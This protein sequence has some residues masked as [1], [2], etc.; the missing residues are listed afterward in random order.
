MCRFPRATTRASRASVNE[1]E[2][3]RPPTSRMPPRADLTSGLAC[4]HY[5]TRQS[6]AES[7]LT[8]TPFA[9]N[10][11][12]H[13]CHTMPPRSAS[14]STILPMLSSPATGTERKYAVTWIYGRE[15][16]ETRIHM[17]CHPCWHGHDTCRSHALRRGT[18]LYR[19]GPRRRCRRWCHWRQGNWP[20][21]A[22]SRHRAG[23]AARPRP[24][25]SDNARRPHQ[26][27]LAP[28]PPLESALADPT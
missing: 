28:T 15:H 2:H 11:K 22:A 17:W 24:R 23:A 10:H 13:R 16:T 5:T 7:C 8:F 21:P 1:T 26:P 27:R 6:H 18:P 20:H 25:V 12:A 4:E 3:I 9:R 14:P 19:V